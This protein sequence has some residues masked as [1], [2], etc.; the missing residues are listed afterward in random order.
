MLI[1]FYM[2]ASLP[3]LCPL[4][5][6]VSKISHHPKCLS[7]PSCNW[8]QNVSLACPSLS[9]WFLVVQWS[10]RI[11][12]GLCFGGHGY[13][14]VW[15]D[16]QYLF[17][18][19]PIEWLMVVGV[20]VFFF[21]FPASG[22]D[23]VVGL[24]LWFG[25]GFGFV[26]CL[27]FWWLGVKVVGG[28]DNGYGGGWVIGC[29]VGFVASGL[30]LVVAG[31]FFFFLIFLFV[32]NGGGWQRMKRSIGVMGW[33]RSWVQWRWCQWN[34]DWRWSLG[35]QWSLDRRWDEGLGEMGQ[36]RGTSMKMKIGNEDEPRT[37]QRS[38]E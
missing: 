20:F 2:H 7:S 33:P 8:T 27:W 12:S 14:A 5:L 3:F 11:F 37:D 38:R 23:A 34:L 36:W 29:W 13:L 1:Y 28:G 31:V 32:F 30:W 6:P 22:G 35:R 21:L 17:F 15:S 18:M 24:S 25:F 26:I 10:D 9:L 19:G 4:L 16:F